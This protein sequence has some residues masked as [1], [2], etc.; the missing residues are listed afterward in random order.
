MDGDELLAVPLELVRSRLVACAALHTYWPMFSSDRD[1]VA[2]G[3]VQRNLPKYKTQTLSFRLRHHS[4][5]HSVVQYEA[6]RSVDF[7][8]MN[9]LDVP[10]VIDDEAVR[11][12]SNNQQGGP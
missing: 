4:R 11:E 9:Q 10:A 5:V 8:I 12:F 1:L 7:S 6:T 2:G 3:V